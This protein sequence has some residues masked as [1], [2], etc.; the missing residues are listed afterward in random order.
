MRFH[1]WTGNE[2]GGAGFEKTAP[3]KEL[4][5]GRFDLGSGFYGAKPARVENPFA[6]SELSGGFPTWGED[7]C[8]AVDDLDNV[9]P[10]DGAG[11]LE[12]KSLFALLVSEGDL[13]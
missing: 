11:I 13:G 12:R 10:L 4:A 1:S 5:N 7:P 9:A 3:E 6:P 2:E 8:D